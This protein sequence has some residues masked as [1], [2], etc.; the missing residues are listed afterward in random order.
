[1]EDKSCTSSEAGQHLLMPNVQLAQLWTKSLK[2]MPNF[3]HI[4]KLCTENLLFALKHAQG[5]LSK[6]DFSRTINSTLASTRKQFSRNLVT[7][8]H[9]KLL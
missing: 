9:S 6:A 8:S 1:M 2:H 4:H 5:S 7:R 3:T